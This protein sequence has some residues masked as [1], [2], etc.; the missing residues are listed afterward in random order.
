MRQRH[1]TGD[2]RSPVALALEESLRDA[3]GA[4]IGNERMWEEAWEEMATFHLFGVLGND[5]LWRGYE[6]VALTEIRVEAAAAARATKAATAGGRMIM[7]LPPQHQQ[8]SSRV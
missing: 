7:R 3:I 4:T 6:W 8:A 2:G 5:L 1:S